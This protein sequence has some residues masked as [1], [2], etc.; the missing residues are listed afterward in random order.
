MAVLVYCMDTSVT[1]MVGLV[2]LLTLSANGA[3]ATDGTPLYKQVGAPIPDRVND[4][5]GR[6]TQAEKVPLPVPECH[7]ALHVHDCSDFF[8]ES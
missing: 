5:V 8:H 1:M 7:T 4:L 6:M 3:F 2:L